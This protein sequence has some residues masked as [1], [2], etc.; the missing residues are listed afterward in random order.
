MFGCLNIRSVTNKLDDLLDVRRDLNID[1]LFLVETWH[2]ADSVGFRRLRA[3]GFQVVDRP[4]PR[5]R[6]DTLSTNHGGVAAVAVNGVQLTRLDVGVSCTSCELLCVRVAAGASSCVAVVVYRTGPVTSAFFND[7]SDVLDRIVTYADPIYVVGDVNIR[8]DRPGD[9]VSRQFT[10]TL[11][12]HG[13]TCR[14][15]TPTHDR[16]GLLDIVATRDD[17]PA[18]SVEVVD[19]GL[20]DHRLLQWTV[21]LVRPCPEYT[22]RKCRPSDRP[23]SVC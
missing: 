19:I 3:D 1:V 9:P 20:S 2:D 12:T 5:L 10:D 14:V 23:S 21:S 18:P 4:R 6:A 16:G 17:L 13:L 8:L 22:T 7:L 11:A 15:T